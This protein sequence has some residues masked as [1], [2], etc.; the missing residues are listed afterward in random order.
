MRK[1]ILILV[2]FLICLN[3]SGC[4]AAVY[5]TSPET[6]PTSGSLRQETFPV[7]F[8][9][10]DG[11]TL[12]G[13]SGKS[14]EIRQNDQVIGGIRLTDLHEICIVDSKCDHL[15]DYLR[16]IAPFPLLVEYISMYDNR[17][18]YI[19]LKITDP[20]TDQVSEQ[21]HHLFL[22]DETYFDFWVDTSIVSNEERDSIF[23]AVEE[24]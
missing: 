3:L 18:A 23:K 21:S 9:V 22:K 5:E 1:F 11:Y 4:S 24:S 14:M 13:A 2:I 15:S 12:A 6:E 8:A 17:D 7:E 16:D 19:S 10:P 20:E